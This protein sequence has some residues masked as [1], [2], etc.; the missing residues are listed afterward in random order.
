VEFRSWVDRAGPARTARR[1][2]GVLEPEPAAED[3]PGCGQSGGAAAGAA[4]AADD[5]DDDRPVGPP[6]RTASGRAGAFAAADGAA[7]VAAAAVASASATWA[8]P[9]PHQRPRPADDVDIVQVAAAAEHSIHGHTHPRRP[10]FPVAAAWPGDPDGIADGGRGDAGQDVHGDWATSA[11]D[12]ACRAEHRID[13]S[14]IDRV[15]PSRRP[16]HVDE[17][18]DADGD[19]DA[20]EDA[21]G[22]GHAGGDAPLTPPAAAAGSPASHAAW[23]ARSDNCRKP[24]WCP[25]R[26]RNS[27]D[28]GPPGHHWPVDPRE[29]VWAIACPGTEHRYHLAAV[30]WDS[31]WAWRPNSAGDPT[32]G[33]GHQA[34]GC[35][36]CGF[37]TA[38]SP[39]SAPRRWQPVRPRP[40]W[41]WP[42]SSWS[43][44]TRADYP[45]RRAGRS[46]GCRRDRCSCTAGRP[47]SSSSSPPSWC[48]ASAL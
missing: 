38:I 3:D 43:P 46:P 12:D 18:A 29:S 14:E 42:A 28:P 22:D 41:A 23:P 34:Y 33:P 36:S 7:G 1:P 40:G 47:R 30:A 20:D 19:G 17:D 25:A 13:H 39:T 8:R 48:R 10:P 27:G 32:R 45:C 16:G 6:K 15:P 21:D 5:G 37:R 11:A 2:G 26:S 24:D 4:T 35:T 44:C 9:H 31:E